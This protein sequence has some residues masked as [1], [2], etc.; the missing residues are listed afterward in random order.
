MLDK[1]FERAVGH[2]RLVAKA[3]GGQP[4]QH[5]IGAHRPMR[6]QQ[7]LERATP[8]RRHP[9]TVF[10]HKAIRAGHHVARATGMIMLGKSPRVKRAVHVSIP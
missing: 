3:F 5:V 4:L 6:F 7:D 2:G 8:D 9:D 1:E 10:A